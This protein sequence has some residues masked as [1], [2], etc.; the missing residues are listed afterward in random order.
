MTSLA[1]SRIIVCGKDT[2]GELNCYSCR[3][4]NKDRGEGREKRERETKQNIE[5]ATAV[6]NATLHNTLVQYV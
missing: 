1:N 3:M 2:A 5:N 4:S 6:T